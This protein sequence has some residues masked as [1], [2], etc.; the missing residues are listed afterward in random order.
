MFCTHMKGWKYVIIY[1]C[2]DMFNYTQALV[3]C[4]SVAYIRQVRFKFGRFDD[5]IVD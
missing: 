3:I 5:V 2:L 1:F 4:N